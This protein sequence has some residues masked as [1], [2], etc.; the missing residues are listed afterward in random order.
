MTKE[1]EIQILEN[2]LKDIEQQAVEGFKIYGDEVLQKFDY[3]N[4]KR[5]LQY[6]KEQ[7]EKNKKW[8]K[9]LDERDE[10]PELDWSKENWVNLYSSFELYSGDEAE[11]IN[12]QPRKF[13]VIVEVKHK[14]HKNISSYVVSKNGLYLPSQ[15]GFW[16][17]KFDIQ[18]RRNVPHKYE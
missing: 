15:I 17:I 6:C 2:Q 16:E 4:K 12:A 5:V 13:D 11:V 18:D 1:Q 10:R 3:E 9:F 8:Y 7:F 14:K